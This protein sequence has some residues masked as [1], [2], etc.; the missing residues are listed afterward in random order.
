MTTE[1]K[2]AL[3]RRRAET[4]L[5]AAARRAIELDRSRRRR[6]GETEE[7][8][9]SRKAANRDRSRRRR[10]GETP[11]QKYRRRA[12]DREYVRRRRLM[13]PTLS[14]DDTT[15]AQHCHGRHATDNFEAASSDDFTDTET[16][17][18]GTLIF[19]CRHCI[20]KFFVEEWHWQSPAP[21]SL[22]LC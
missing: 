1:C 12:A 14:S 11:E 19:Q 7:Q 13:E 22:R 4:E 6:D 16:H 20:V 2:R 9:A 10:A 5:Q 21:V 17:Y 3:R 18:C 8:T 15:S